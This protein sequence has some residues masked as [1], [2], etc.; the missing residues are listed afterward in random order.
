MPPSWPRGRQ[1]MMK[2]GLSVGG[3]YVWNK[4]KSLGKYLLYIS[5]VSSCNRGNGSFMD[6][7]RFP[8]PFPSMVSTSDIKGDGHTGRPGCISLDEGLAQVTSTRG[9]R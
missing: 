3:R 9:L 4:A 5:G 1:G 8:Y 2:I 7:W 6:S